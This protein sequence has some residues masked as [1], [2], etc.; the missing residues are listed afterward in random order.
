VDLLVRTL[1]ELHKGVTHCSRENAADLDIDVYDLVRCDMTQ[2]V[3]ACFAGDKVVL[4]STTYYNEVFPSM[5]SF[6]NHLKD[7]AFQNRKVALI[8]NGSWGP[9]AASFMKGMLEDCPGIDY[10]EPTVTIKSALNAASREQITS[11]AKEL[12]GIA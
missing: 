11:L 4:A 3:A 6:I 8:E 10:A 12:L 5:K 7:S 9:K 2:A 1:K